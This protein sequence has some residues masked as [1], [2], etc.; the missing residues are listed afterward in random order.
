MLRAFY[1]FVLVAALFATSAQAETRISICHGYSCVGQAEIGYSQERLDE[2]RRLLGAANDAPTE[3]V[4]LAQ[5]MGL[6]YRW[7]GE[8]SEIKNDRAGNYADGHVPGK[9][10]CI[11]HS[12][13]S[14]R[15]LHVL[16]NAGMLRWH[17][18][19]APDVRYFLLFFPSH[20][21]AVIEEIADDKE[22]NADKAARFVVD[23]WFVNNGEAAV[24]LPLEDWKKG[25]GP[26]V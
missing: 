14:T 1:C 10:D 2:I 21:S 20:W 24:I 19:L 5:A 15:L 17:R 7:A 23:T 25:A 11:D 16:E 12:I 8:Q 3:R 4:Q 26:D 13:S 22:Q 6:L 18:V 9:M